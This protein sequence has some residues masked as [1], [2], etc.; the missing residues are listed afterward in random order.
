MPVNPNKPV[1]LPSLFFCERFRVKGLF[2]CDH[3]NPEQ[4]A[5]PQHIT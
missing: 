5:N 2:S 3:R 4:Q 1:S